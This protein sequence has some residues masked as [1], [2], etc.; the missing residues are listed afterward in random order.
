MRSL[1]DFSRQELE[2][3]VAHVVVVL[4][5]DD[6]GDKPNECILGFNPDLEWDSETI[7]M[8][9]SKFNGLDLKP[10]PQESPEAAIEGLKAWEAS[11]TPK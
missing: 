7:D 6:V 9:A 10:D 8:I 3:L 4:W 11:G 5:A 1:K 2:E